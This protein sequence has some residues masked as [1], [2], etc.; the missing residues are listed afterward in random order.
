MY[1]PLEMPPPVKVNIPRVRNGDIITVRCEDTDCER[2]RLLGIMA[3]AIAEAYNP[4][5][6]YSEQYREDNYLVK[7]NI[8]PN[9]MGIRAVSDKIVDRLELIMQ[10]LMNN[11]LDTFV[12]ILNALEVSN[13]SEAIATDLFKSFINYELVTRR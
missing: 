10:I 13:S 7:R 11:N 6:S 1:D 4:F 12:A 5:R 3:I 2:A 8:P 9:P